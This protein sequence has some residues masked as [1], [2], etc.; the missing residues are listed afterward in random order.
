M[1]N[2]CVTVPSLPPLAPPA[3]QHD[4]TPPRLLPAAGSTQALHTLPNAAVDVL[5]MP[6][7]V[8]GKPQT[9][10]GS[11]P[12]LG[13]A[14]KTPANQPRGRQKHLAWVRRRSPTG[15]GRPGG[16]V[17]WDEREQRQ[18]HHPAAGRDGAEPRGA[19]PAGTFSSEGG[20]GET[21][22]RG[23]SHPP[24]MLHPRINGVQGPRAR[25]APQKLAFHVPPN[26]RTGYKAASASGPK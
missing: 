5:E 15:Q 22:A 21:S 7:E 17:T 11:P 24:L 8:H 3:P 20:H 4:P 6:L 16:A 25:A 2:A 23:N 1:V 14:A 18:Q 13:A 10:P 9:H 12:P 26:F 19:A